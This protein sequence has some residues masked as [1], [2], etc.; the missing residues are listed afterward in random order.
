MKK[1]LPFDVFKD[2]CFHAEQAILVSYAYEDLS[3]FFVPTTRIFVIAK[4]DAG[5][6]QIAEAIIAHYVVSQFANT[7]AAELLKRVDEFKTGETLQ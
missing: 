2:A 1:P 4:T 3:I 7:A 5:V 6:K